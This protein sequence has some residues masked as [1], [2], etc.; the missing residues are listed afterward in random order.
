[1]GVHYR[2]ISICRIISRMKQTSS[3]RQFKIQMKKLF[4]LLL[5]LFL[6]PLA[7]RAEEAETP[8]FS[9]L[10]HLGGNY[11]TGFIPATSPAP[12]GGLWLG[13]SLSNRFDGLWGMDYYTMPADLVTL[14]LPSP[15]DPQ[16]IKL[17]NPR[18]NFA[19][20]VNVR[21]YLDDK[22]D[23]LHKRF[24]T[25]PYLVGGLGMDFMIDQHDWD[26]NSRFYNATYDLLVSMNLG[27]G[28][29]FPLGDAQKWFIYAEG[30]DHLVF[31]QGLTQIFSVRT[32]VKVMLDGAHLDPFRK[33]D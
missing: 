5:L 6:A 4:P 27:G 12:A 25:T 22:W 31:W 28:V 2:N 1:M 23:S 16:T 3:Q 26:S 18:D 10:F 24:N 17:V 32:G 20:T 15:S 33:A 7:S 19:L 21:C 9:A 13:I 11:S 14:S 30:L 8:N 29:D